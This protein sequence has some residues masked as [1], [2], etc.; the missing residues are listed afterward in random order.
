VGNT[1]AFCS[2]DRGSNL[3]SDDGYAHR[4]SRGF[5][6]PFRYTPIRYLKLI[7]R[8]PLP[9]TSHSIRYSVYS[10][11]PTSYSLCYWQLHL[12]HEETR[13]CFPEA[14]ACDRVRR[15]RRTYRPGVARELP[16][17]IL[18][19]A[20]HLQRHTSKPRPS[21][22]SSL[23]LTSFKHFQQKFEFYMSYFAALPH[24]H[25]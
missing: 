8:R 14:F 25:L 11:H 21:R 18:R 10:H 1:S 19:L 23:P 24:R 15:L 16:A 20:P 6:S 5:L 13:Q 9:S 22:V 3:S 4:V 7:K 12:M 17:D 2:R